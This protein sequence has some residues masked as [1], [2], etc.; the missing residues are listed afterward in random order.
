MRNFEELSDYDFE[1]LVAD[2]LSARWKTDVEIFPRGRDGG[3]DL[4]ALGPTGAPLHLTA[5]DELVVQCKHRPNA[6]LSG[7]RTDLRAEAT[8]P[9]VDEAARYVLVTSARLTRHNKQ[10]IVDIF[11]GRISPGDVLAQNDI[12]AL[13]R[14]HPEV[15]RTNI[16]L[17]LTSGAVLQTLI[18]QI[19]HLRSAALKSDLLRLRSTF[20]ETSIVT[21]ARQV[22][23]QFGVCVLAGP[24]GVGKTTTGLILLLQYLAKGWRPITAVAHVRELEAQLLPNVRQILFFDD[25][26]G[27]NSLE[28][29]FDRGEDSELVRL[30]RMVEDDPTKVFILTTRDYVLR[31]AKQSYERLG[32]ELLQLAKVT[33]TTEGITPAQRV[34]IL[35]NQLYFSPL[36]AQAAAAPN[37][38]HRYE[39]LTR[40]H[41]YNPRLLDAAISAVSRKLGLRAQRPSLGDG[42]ETAAQ[43]SPEAAPARLLSSSVQA[44]SLDIPRALHSALDNPDQLWDHILRYQLTT[45]QQELLLT[46]VSFGAQSIYLTS[47]FEAAGAFVAANG[48]RTTTADLDSALHVLDG[49]FFTLTDTER[50]R[51][52]T[53]V[54]PVNPGLTDA[55]VAFLRRYPDHLSRLA[56]SATSF[57]QVRWIAA[58]CGVMK[59]RRSPRPARLVAQNIV[60]GLVPSAERTLTSPSAFPSGDVPLSR[61]SRFSDFGQRLEL[62]AALYMTSGCESAPGLADETIPPFLAAIGNIPGGELLRVVSALRSQALRTWRRRRTE[63]DVAVLRLLDNPDDIASW[64]LLRDVLDVVQT[65]PEYHEDLETRFEQFLEEALDQARDALE[66]EDDDLSAADL[67]LDELDELASRWGASTSDIDE[68]AEQIEAR[69][70]NRPPRHSNSRPSLITP[71]ATLE[72]A[73]TKS[74]FNYL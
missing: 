57:A 34:H 10:E 9:I 63:V 50:G 53:L 59:E 58:A 39:A 74:L 5:G 6:V 56:T 23:E 71:A 30:I 7:L 35:Y 24:P 36:R 43:A 64:S 40:H 67:D 52:A 60:Q 49:D 13:L 17:W 25:F 8:R 20:V 26:L 44:T 41:N 55:A 14:R 42:S 22:I 66:D 68:I 61:E 32:D 29:K 31:Q 70:D 72:P 33:V 3:V 11:G 16:K 19:E 62:L 4:R 65:T 46:R 2:L 73:A 69:Q 15:E 12:A 45:L 28:A 47:L 21:K 27:Q 1:R 51:G 48:H 37:G 18:H 54:D 38:P